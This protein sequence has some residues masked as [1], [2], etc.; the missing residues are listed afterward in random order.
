MLHQIARNCYAGFDERLT[1][2]SCPM[3]WSWFCALYFWNSESR[4]NYTRL[5]MVLPLRSDK[6]SLL[7]R[8]A[9]VSIRSGDQ[10]LMRVESSFVV[11]VPRGVFSGFSGSPL[12]KFFGFPPSVQLT[13]Q[14]PIIDASYKYSY[15]YGHFN[16]VYDANAIQ[17]NMI[18]Y[19]QAKLSIAKIFCALNFWE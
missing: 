1:D 11:P 5:G 3:F 9:G 13:L 12:I 17:Y 16:K 6:E 2:L 14:C 15:R 8:L 4:V 10:L 7:V 19:G 18:W